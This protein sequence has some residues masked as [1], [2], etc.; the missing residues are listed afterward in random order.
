MCAADV[1]LDVSPK[2]NLRNMSSEFGWTS[3]LTLIPSS[4]MFSFNLPLVL[5][6]F[7]LFH[8]SGVLV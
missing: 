3:G 4:N 7:L 6:S 8:M 5:L 2:Q 1:A